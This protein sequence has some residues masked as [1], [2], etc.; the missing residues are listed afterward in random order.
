[1]HRAKM[2]LMFNWC[3]IAELSRIK[4]VSQGGVIRISN[5][6]KTASLFRLGHL[7]MLHVQS[8]E[9]RLS[10]DRMKR[11]SCGVQPHEDGII[12]LQKHKAQES[13]DK[14]PAIAQQ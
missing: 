11:S 2:S 4:R 8:S 12:E 5:L 9:R 3:I 1:M 7:C 6:P 10:T 14:P 13:A